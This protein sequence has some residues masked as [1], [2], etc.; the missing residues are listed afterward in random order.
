MDR[1]WRLLTR[2]YFTSFP[3]FLQELSTACSSAS[4]PKKIKLMCSCPVSVHTHACQTERQSD[5]PSLKHLWS[6]L[7]VTSPPDNRHYVALTL[8]KPKS[9]GRQEMLPV[10]PLR[11]RLQCGLSTLIRHQITSPTTASSQGKAPEMSE[12]LTTTHRALG[13]AD[14][15]TS[16]ATQTTCSQ[17]CH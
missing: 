10:P 12:S 15:G 4:V 3:V 7:V 16:A 17:K 2:R 14:F 11:D 9:E 13:K 6:L 8:R 1:V 5:C